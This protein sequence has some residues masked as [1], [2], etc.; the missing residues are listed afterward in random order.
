[1]YILGELIAMNSF[2]ND[3]KYDNGKKKWIAKKSVGGGGGGTL[4]KSQRSYRKVLVGVCEFSFNIFK[5]KD[6]NTN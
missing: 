4:F 2:L 5:V 6:C 3:D 1:M